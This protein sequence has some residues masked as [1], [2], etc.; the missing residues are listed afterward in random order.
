MRRGSDACTNAIS[1]TFRSESAGWASLRQSPGS[2][3]AWWQRGVQL[4]AD[5]KIEE[6]RKAQT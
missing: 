5:G 1:K 2:S 4:F 6:A 3:I